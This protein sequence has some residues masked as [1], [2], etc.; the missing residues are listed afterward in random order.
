[1]KVEY[2]KEAD[3]A[4]IYLK[5]IGA[6]EVK[7]TIELNEDIILDFDKNRKLVGIEILNASKV[8]PKTAVSDL[9]NAAA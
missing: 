6:G 2:D 1:M 3:A 4:Y 8:M 9:V 5:K 7:K